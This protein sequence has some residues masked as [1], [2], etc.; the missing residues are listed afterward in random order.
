MLFSSLTFLFYFLPLTVIL[1]YV[2]PFRFWRN[3]ILL[4]ASLL[5]YSWGEPKMVFLMVIEVMLTYLLGE[6]LITVGLL[7]L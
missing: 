4:A 3:L 7:L 6:C 1:Y 5:F 2:L